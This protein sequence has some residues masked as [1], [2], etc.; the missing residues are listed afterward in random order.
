MRP[1]TTAI[2]DV[3]EP[4]KTAQEID[5]GIDHPSLQAWRASQPS[6]AR[7]RM[8]HHALIRA[9]N[10]AVREHADAPFERDAERRQERDRDADEERDRARR[11]NRDGLRPRLP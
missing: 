4:E 9:A 6:N 2:T 1:V 3:A 5:A 10:A 8:W 7:A 11:P